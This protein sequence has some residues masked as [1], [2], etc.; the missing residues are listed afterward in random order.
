MSPA[1]GVLRP[2]LPQPCSITHWQG[3]DVICTGRPLLLGQDPGRGRWG[4]AAVSLAVWASEAL[5]Q[6]GQGCIHISL[7]EPPE[8]AA[9]R[10]QTRVGPAGSLLRRAGCWKVEKRRA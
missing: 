6:Q 4:G 9:E 10:P 2:G 7:S 1:P 3:R 8:E 5:C